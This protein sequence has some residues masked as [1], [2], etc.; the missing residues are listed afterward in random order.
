LKVENGHPNLPAPGVNYRCLLALLLLSV[1]VAPVAAERP[2]SIR[3]MLEEA[4]QHLE[5]WEVKQYEQMLRCAWEH[6]DGSAADR[7]E[8]GQELA[9]CLLAIKHDPQE[10]REVLSAAQALKARPALPL[11]ELAELEIFEG[12]SARALEITPS[13][14][15]VP[16]RLQSGLENDI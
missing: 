16:R 4:F 13:D 2:Q 5:R 1:G 8:A 11:L 9:R 12:H 6:G 15:L 10:A 7:V 3:S 14:S